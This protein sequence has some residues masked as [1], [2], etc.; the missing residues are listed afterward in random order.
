M[1]IEKEYEVCW[2]LCEEREKHFV[3]HKMWW[4]RLNHVEILSVEHM[5]LNWKRPFK[6][7]KY[8][9][10]PKYLLKSHVKN[11]TYTSHQ[12]ILVYF[13]FV[14]KPKTW[15]NKCC[16]ES[17]ACFVLR[18]DVDISIFHV[19]SISC[20]CSVAWVVRSF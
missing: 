20:V 2:L 16:V 1:R 4:R 10:L 17:T 19:L 13:I 9:T 15:I 18:I 14:K 6:F 5:E 12:T 11:I 8:E 3:A 7:L